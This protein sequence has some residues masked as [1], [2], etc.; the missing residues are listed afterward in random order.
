MDGLLYGVQP[1]AD[2]TRH[3][4]GAVACV[5]TCWFV[6]AAL[7]ARPSFL[8]S[9]PLGLNSHIVL[10]TVLTAVSPWLHCPAAPQTCTTDSYYNGMS[11]PEYICC[12]NEYYAEHSGFL[13]DSDVDFFA[14]LVLAGAADDGAAP[15]TF[16]DSELLEGLRVDCIVVLLI[17]DRL[18][19]PT[20]VHTTQ[21]GPILAKTDI[22]RAYFHRMPSRHVRHPVVHGAHRPLVRRVEERKPTPRLAQLP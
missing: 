2:D 5:R 13:D 7:P 9:V 18:R 10:S 16:Y 8:P 12:N 17:G 20:S 22:M 1:Y 15:T 14:R 11:L 19:V 21:A 3:V 6:C 4:L